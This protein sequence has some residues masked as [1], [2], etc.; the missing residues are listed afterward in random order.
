MRVGELG[1]RTM[2]LGRRNRVGRCRALNFDTLSQEPASTSA[3][4]A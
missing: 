1:R 4:P 2:A 3:S